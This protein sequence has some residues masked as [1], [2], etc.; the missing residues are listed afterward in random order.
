[1]SIPP[2]SCLSC[3]L[4]KP[5]Q[6]AVPLMYS[7]LIL[8]NL[9]TPSENSNIFNSATSISASCLLVSATGS[10]PYYIAGLNVTLYTFPFIL[11]GTRLSQITRSWHS[12]PPIPSCLYSL[13]HFSSA[14]SIT[15]NV[16]LS[17]GTVYLKSST[18][19]TSSH[20]IFTVPLT[21]LSFTHTFCLSP[22]DFHSSFSKAYIQLSSFSS[23]CS[24]LSRQITM[25]SVN[26][27]VH[28]ASSLISSYP[29]PFP[30]KQGLKADRWCSPT[31]TSNP[32]AI[33]TAHLT[34]VI[35]II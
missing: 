32:S 28:G 33:P 26:I 34:A 19:A 25:S 23:T 15:S 17:T 7:F 9:V 3:F 16:Q 27:T 29:S 11:A 10:N 13:L 21:C 4:S 31:F 2:Q 20:C 24:L 18:F 12:S 1:M 30:N 6:R 14:L 22:C 35:I 8:S 5:S